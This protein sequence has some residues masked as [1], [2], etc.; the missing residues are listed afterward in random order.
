MESKANKVIILPETTKKPI[1]L[2]GKRAGICWGADIEDDEKNYKRGLDCLESNHGRVLEFVNIEAVFD[3]WSAR[4]IR[5]WYTHI[6][7]A[8]TRLQ[9]STRYINYSKGFDYV[10]PDKIRKD[11]KAL[12]KYND[13]MSN[14]RKTASILESEFCIPR[15]DVANLFPLGMNT[16]IVDKRNL[17]NV[18]DMSRQR[19]CTRAYWEFRKLFKAYADELKKIDDEWAYIVD[20]YFMPKCEML[21][22]CPE[23]YSCGRKPKKEKKQRD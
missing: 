13:V 20:N 2:M 22:Y 8:P 12:K 6:G 21:G 9:A 17:R 19:M 3:G 7:G 15:E 14:I 18:I 10:I 16:K 5:E 23:K 4:L 11:T 1:T